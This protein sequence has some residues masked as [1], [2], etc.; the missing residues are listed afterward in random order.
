MEQNLSD[1]ERRKRLALGIL[2]L[3]AGGIRYG[4]AGWAP[5]VGVLM[6]L[7]V[8]FILNYFMCFCATKRVLRR[9]KNGF[10]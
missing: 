6:A 1:R 5:L 8:G 10:A 9:I 3:T 7:G 4:T 2:C